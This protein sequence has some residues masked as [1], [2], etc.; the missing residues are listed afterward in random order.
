M[1]A[2]EP[3]RVPRSQ[4]GRIA[5]SAIRRPWGRYLPRAF[6]RP[7]KPT[8][9]RPRGSTPARMPAEPRERV[10]SQALPFQQFHVLFNSL[11]KSCIPKQLDSSK[12]LH[13]GADTPSHTGFSPSMTSRSRALRWGPLPKHPL[14]ITMRT[15]K[16]PAFKFELLP[17]HSPLLGQS[18][19]VSFPPLIDMLK[20]SGYPYLIRGQPG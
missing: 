18:L 8:L 1:P 2:S 14:Q 9:A 3:K 5:P 15:P 7:P 6:D 12:E 19:L 4:A 10:W 20:F 16:E 13:T 11:F 17:L